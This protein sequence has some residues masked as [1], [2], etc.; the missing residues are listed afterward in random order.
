MTSRCVTAT[1]YSKNN[2]NTA[3][4]IIKQFRFY[5]NLL[6]VSNSRLSSGEDVKKYTYEGRTNIERGLSLT[7]RCHISQ[8]YKN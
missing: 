7:E 6:R 8:T 4:F 3:T 5:K 2:L 1:K